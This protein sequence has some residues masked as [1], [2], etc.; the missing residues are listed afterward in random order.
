MIELEI[1]GERIQMDL[2]QKALQKFP[3]SGKIIYSSIERIG[4]RRYKTCMVTKFG[5][6]VD[7]YDSVERAAAFLQEWYIRHGA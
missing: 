3:S 1:G 4:A 2:S 6:W 7:E 5:A